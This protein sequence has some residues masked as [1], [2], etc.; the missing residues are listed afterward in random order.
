MIKPLKRDR[1]RT[2]LSVFCPC[3]GDPKKY[4]KKN[5][6]FSSNGVFRRKSSKNHKM[7]KNSRNWAK[8]GQNYKK[9]LK[10]KSSILP[11]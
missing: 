3:R 11:R 1:S 4:E 6:Y 9:L 7:V 10:L 5:S 2:S 8:L